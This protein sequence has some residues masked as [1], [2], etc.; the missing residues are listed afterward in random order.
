MVVRFHAPLG[1]KWVLK[2]RN[3]AMFTRHQVEFSVVLYIDCSI[4]LDRLYECI[5][6]KIGRV[7][8]TYSDK[9]TIRQYYIYYL[10]LLPV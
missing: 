3:V 4:E 2:A 9:P 5:A 8:V 10:L 7:V 6:A 1:I